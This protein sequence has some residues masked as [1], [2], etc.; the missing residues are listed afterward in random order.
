[1][2]SFK[3]ALRSFLA[4]ALAVCAVKNITVDD[5]DPRI[6][7]TN[8][9]VWTHES[10]GATLDRFNLTT[11]YT[12]DQ[13]LASIKFN[14]T[15]VYFISYGLPLPYPDQYQVTIDGQTETESLRVSNESERAQFMAYARTGLD[16]SSEHQITIS[17]P[18]KISLN[19]DAFIFTVLDNS[20]MQDGFGTLSGSSK[21]GTQSTQPTQSTDS[22]GDSGLS[23]ATKAGIAVALIGGILLGLLGALGISYWQKRR[24]SEAQGYPSDP[25]GAIEGG[26]TIVQTQETRQSAAVDVAPFVIAAGGVQTRPGEFRKERRPNGETY[27]S[28]EA[29]GEMDEQATTIS[30][31]TSPRM[32]PS[33]PSV[34]SA[35]PP[36]YAG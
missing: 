11:S 7:Y 16:A 2:L 28:P 14:G 24:K 19:I 5:F 9:S 15:A 33:T 20:T 18:F 36:P 23:A 30:G 27:R 4:S 17:N 29:P 22:K 10:D 32:P 8:P 6:V 3:F 31:V 26:A 25:I 35:F 12:G 21:N 13:A 34:I 1:M